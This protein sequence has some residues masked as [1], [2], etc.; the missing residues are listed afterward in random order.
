M[1]LYGSVLQ[2]AGED[3]T[4]TE[5]QMGGATDIETRPF[6]SVRLKSREYM[7]HKLVLQSSAIILPD[8]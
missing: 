7:W 6:D 8:N 1:L 5:D 4:H 2:D 3:V